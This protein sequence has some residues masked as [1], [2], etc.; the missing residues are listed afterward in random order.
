MKPI[1]FEGQNVIFGKD[2]PEYQPLPAYRSDDGTVTTCWELEEADV[3]ILKAKLEA[4]EPI[5]LW[6]SQLTFN[7]PLQP[8]LPLLTKPETIV[9]PETVP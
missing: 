8:Q 4:G 2:Q 1:F 7:G 3:A 5:Q 9:S 6:L